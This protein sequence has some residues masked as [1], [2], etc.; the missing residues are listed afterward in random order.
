MELMDEGFN[1]QHRICQLM[2]C[3]SEQ[4]KIAVDAIRVASA[5]LPA[6]KPQLQLSVLGLMVRVPPSFVVSPPL[7]S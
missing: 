3:I 5:M 2:D 1:F 4:V 7:V 6:S